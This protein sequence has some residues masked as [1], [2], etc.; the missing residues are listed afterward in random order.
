MMQSFPKSLSTKLSSNV[1]MFSRFYSFLPYA[2]I[3]ALITLASYAFSSTTKVKV[4]APKYP[5]GRGSDP[6]AAASLKGLNSYPEMNIKL[7]PEV[8]IVRNPFAS[9]SSATTDVS[10]PAPNISLKGFAGLGGLS[11]YVFLSIDGAQ[12]YQFRVGQEIGN[13]FRI[14]A[15]NTNAKNIVV[16]NGKSRFKYQLKDL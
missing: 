6:V 4:L 15:I 2:T 9:P 1:Q 3:I 16:S 11:Q 13:G 10:T 5:G 8:S 7:A 12:T 14:V